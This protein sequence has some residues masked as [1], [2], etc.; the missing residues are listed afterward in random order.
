MVKDSVLSLKIR[1]EARLCAF[2]TAIQHI[3]GSS[4]QDNKARKGNKG[5]VGQTK[6]IQCS[7]L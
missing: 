6:E 4:S 2:N 7:Y 3:T 1:N 5:H